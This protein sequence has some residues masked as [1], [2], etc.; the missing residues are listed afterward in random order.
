MEN[1]ISSPTHVDADTIGM[2][3][4]RRA[5]RKYK[6]ISVD[7][8]LIEQVI[9]AGRMAPTAI[10]QQ[11]WKFY[12]LTDRALISEFGKEIVSVSMKG[13]IRSGIKN[14]VRTASHLI[15]FPHGFD[16]HSLEDPVFHGAP[17]VIFITGP[18][19]N[20]W[21][22][23]D[24]GMCTQNMMLAAKALGLDSC[25]IGFAKYAKETK[26]FPRLNLPDADE[27]I[28]AVILGYGNEFPEL[29]ERKRNNVF[30][31]H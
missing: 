6:K 26:L 2:I 11:V 31:V 28:I 24:I 29:H 17:V 25:P 4:K 9:D 1:I 12:V 13:F 15:H 21:A 18:K 27:V 30:F 20:E 22:H 19:E 14:I 16:F 7:Q 10:N 3:Y 23:L 5:V 8:E